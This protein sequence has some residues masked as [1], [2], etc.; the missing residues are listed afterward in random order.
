MADLFAVYVV[1]EAFIVLMV[2]CQC[3]KLSAYH[4][5]RNL[6]VTFH[7][8]LCSLLEI[9]KAFLGIE[10]GWLV[11]VIPKGI[12]SFGNENIVFVAKPFS[13]IGI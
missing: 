6:R 4:V 7:I 10:D 1:I 13:G 2:V 5:V 12:D 8:F 9:S 11:H 3:L